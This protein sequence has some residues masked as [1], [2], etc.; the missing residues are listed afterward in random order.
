MPKI[1]ALVLLAVLLAGLSL[2]AAEEKK[3]EPDR[4]RKALERSLLFPGL[5]QLAEKQYVKAAAFASAEIFCLV[6]VAVHHAARATT[7][8]ATTAMPWT[9]TRRWSG[10]CGPRPTTGGA[11]PPSWPR[12]ASGS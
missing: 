3:A 5:G 8:T 7:P 6:E 2:P 9:R 11:I 4:L 10:A 1:K 12:P